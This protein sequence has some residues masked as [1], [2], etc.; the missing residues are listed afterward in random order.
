MVGSPGPETSDA[1]ANAAY[2]ALEKHFSAERQ[3]FNGLDTISFAGVTY[4]SAAFRAARIRRRGLFQSIPRAQV[5]QDV[6]AA[7][8]DAET[9]DVYEFTVGVYMQNPRFDDLGL[10]GSIWRLALL[11]PGGQVA[12]VLVKR[13]GRA[14]VNTR[15]YYPYMGDFWSVYTVRFPKVLDAR[16]VLPPAEPPTVPTFTVLLASSLGKAEFPLPAQ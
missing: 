6:E 16:P 4:E 15:A 12:P 5:E 1:Q 7:V 11:T 10:P 8:A 9:G 13:V 2:S 3:I 14:D